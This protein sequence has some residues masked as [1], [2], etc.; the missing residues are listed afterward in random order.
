MSGMQGTAVTDR[1]LLDA[2]AVCGHL[3]APGSVCALLAQ[4]RSRLFPDEVFEGLFPS[5]R[6]R[7]SVPGEVAARGHDPFP[8]SCC[9]PWE[10]S[11]GDR[12]SVHFDDQTAET[13]DAFDALLAGVSDCRD[14][15][16]PRDER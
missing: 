11:G 5:G 10:H 6:G 1:E 15:A 3:L 2:A 7:P 12:F 13:V 9:D 14:A 4:H 8:A 16:R